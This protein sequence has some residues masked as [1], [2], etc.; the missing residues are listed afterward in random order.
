MSHHLAGG[1]ETLWQRY[2]YVPVVILIYL[3]FCYKE[4]ISNSKY[5]VIE[6]FKY[7]CNL[8]LHHG[9]P[10][11]YCFLLCVALHLTLYAGTI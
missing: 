1:Q 11:L 5:H 4:L 9:N 7:F 6:R 2:V 3:I 10:M 8:I